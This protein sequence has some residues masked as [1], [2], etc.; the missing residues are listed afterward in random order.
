MYCSKEM[1]VRQGVSSRT[2]KAC[3]TVVH[4]IVEIGP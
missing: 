1:G 3:F 4:I 2:R